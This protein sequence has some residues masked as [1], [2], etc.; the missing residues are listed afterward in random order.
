M[1]SPLLAYNAVLVEGITSVLLGYRATCFATS[2]SWRYSAIPLQ[3][4]NSSDARKRARVFTRVFIP[5]KSQPDASR[6]ARSACH[7][8]GIIIIL[9]F[10]SLTIGFSRIIIIKREI[11]LTVAFDGLLIARFHA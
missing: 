10:L 7:R 6:S 5:R 4:Y 3:L 11:I 1:R 9:V 2:E 8:T